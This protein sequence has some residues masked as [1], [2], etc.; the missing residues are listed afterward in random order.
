MAISKKRKRKITVINK[1]FLYWFY[2]EV[3][4]TEFDGNQIKIILEDQSV[5]LK[6]GLKQQEDKRYVVVALDQNQLKVHIY[7]PQFEREDGIITPAGISRMINW[8]STYEIPD[9]KT[10]LQ[11]AYSPQIGILQGA[12]R[13]KALISIQKVLNKEN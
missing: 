13:K 3:D 2:N 4:Q 7:C 6:Y 1:T 11:H 8:V 5:Y 12:E 9:D 10:E